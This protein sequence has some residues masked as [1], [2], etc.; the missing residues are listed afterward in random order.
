MEFV[1][2]LA[3]TGSI[4][5]VCTSYYGHGHRTT[6]N[7]LLRTLCP[8]R[9]AAR[10]HARTERSRFSRRFPLALILLLGASLVEGSASAEAPWGPWGRV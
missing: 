6:V 4:P 2:I 3:Q 7:T 1:R 10:T 5:F 8:S 9:R